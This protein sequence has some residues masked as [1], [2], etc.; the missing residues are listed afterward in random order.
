MNSGLV[1]TTNNVT[2]F[3]LY[4]T[5]RTVMGTTGMMLAHSVKVRY[6][7]DPTIRGKYTKCPKIPRYHRHQMVRLHRPLH[8][9][10]PPRGPQTPEMHLAVD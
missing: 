10:I 4:A 7:E 9:R 2:P 8:T 6:Q 1:S 3:G 5:C